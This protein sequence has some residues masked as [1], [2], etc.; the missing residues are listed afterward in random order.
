MRVLTEERKKLILA[1]I[2]AL[3]DEHWKQAR[4]AMEELDEAVERH[5]KALI[6]SPKQL[7][8]EFDI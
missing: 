3:D 4:I 6:P 5:R 7:Q 2:A 1:N 8:L